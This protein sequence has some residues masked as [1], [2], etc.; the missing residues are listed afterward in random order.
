MQVKHRTGKL[1]RPKTD[2]TPLCHA[3]H[4]HITSCQVLRIAVLC[5]LTR[6]HKRRQ[7]RDFLALRV[8]LL[9]CQHFATRSVAIVISTCHQRV[10][11][12]GLNYSSRNQESSEELSRKIIITIIIIIIKCFLLTGLYVSEKSN[13]PNTDIDQ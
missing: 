11:I 10:G 5:F 2:V 8:V 1:R 6:C 3:T 4:Q 12:G 7:N 9:L 13:I